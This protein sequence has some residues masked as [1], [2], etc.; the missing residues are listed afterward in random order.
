MVI[1]SHVIA[2]GTEQF[3][4]VLF[5]EI[6]LFFFSFINFVCVLFIKYNILIKMARALMRLGKI[7]NPSYMAA[8]PS[9]SVSSQQ[10]NCK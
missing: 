4:F 1:V 5:S 7:V 6:K 9:L 10:R 8:N 3:Y 2:T